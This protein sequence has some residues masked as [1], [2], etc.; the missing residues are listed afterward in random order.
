VAPALAIALPGALH[1]LRIVRRQEAGE[2]GALNLGLRKP[3]HER[4][5][6]LHPWHMPIS[7]FGE[8]VCMSMQRCAAVSPSRPNRMLVHAATRIGT[9]EF[10]TED[11][12]ISTDLSSYSVIC[13]G[14]G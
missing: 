12:E 14:S 5:Y 4:Q 3:L 1:L 6:A 7:P 8:L 10:S 11:H 13:R 9:L 2:D